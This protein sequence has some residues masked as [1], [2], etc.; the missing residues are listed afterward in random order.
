VTP[1]EL[2]DVL[3]A[4]GRQQVPPPSTDF[5]RE[6]EQ[7]ITST[8]VVVADANRRSP[9]RA[10][11]AVAAAAVILVGVVV[12]QRGEKEQTVVT[13]PT[14]T[15]SRPTTSTSTSS[16]TSLPP[17]TVTSVVTVPATVAITT[18]VVTTT[19]TAAPTTTTTVATTTS[20]TAPGVEDAR[21]SCVTGSRPEV[22]CAWAKNEHPDFKGYRLSKRIADGPLEEVG[23]TTDRAVT[24]KTDK[25]VQVGAR[26]TY[27]LEVL[28]HD[29]QVIA[30]G[31]ATVS[32]C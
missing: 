15:S 26:I 19:T 21:L 20:T 24:S 27:V 29:S 16:T 1:E 14:T 25:D 31:E 30:R 13:D 23:S 11:G 5:V 12:L 32:C 4:A 22:T 8:R 7:R 9:W 17:T 18:S 6:L 3:D 10:V 28:D 2:R